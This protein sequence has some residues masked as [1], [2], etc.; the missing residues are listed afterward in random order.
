MQKK[1]TGL[2]FF[3]LFALTGFA[4]TALT[5]ARVPVTLAADTITAPAAPQP[6]TVSVKKQA[7]AIPARDTGNNPPPTDQ[8]AA[9]Q[10]KKPE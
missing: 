7:T 3:F 6:Q 10:R 8:P 1:L 4:Q 2:L 5:S 9:S